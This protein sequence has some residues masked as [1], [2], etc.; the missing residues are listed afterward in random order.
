[1]ALSEE[2]KQTVIA[3]IN[4]ENYDA[5][6][7]ALSNQGYDNDH[8]EAIKDVFN[9]IATKKG[10]D[11]IIQHLSAVASA[12]E[13]NLNQKPHMLENALYSIFGET[14]ET[15]SPPGGQQTSQNTDTMADIDKL[16]IDDID[17]K[18]T[19][20]KAEQAKLIRENKPLDPEKSKLIKQLRAAKEKLA[21]QEAQA[22]SSQQQEKG[23]WFKFASRDEIGQVMDFSVCHGTVILETIKDRLNTNIKEN[24][25]VLSKQDAVKESQE[26]EFIEAYR[27]EMP[28]VSDGDEFIKEVGEKFKQH[29]RISGKLL[30]HRYGVEHGGLYQIAGGW[31]VIT[32]EEG[33]NKNLPAHHIY[34]L[35]INE[36][37]YFT[38]LFKRRYEGGNIYPDAYTALEFKG[39][40]CIT[41]IRSQKGID[42]IDEKQ[43][44]ILSSQSKAF[45]KKFADIQKE[46]P[47]EIFNIKPSIGE[48]DAIAK[49]LSGAKGSKSTKQ[50]SDKEKQPQQQTQQQEPEEPEK[51]KEEHEDQEEPPAHT[52]PTSGG[53]DEDKLTRLTN[54]LEQA[55]LNNQTSTVKRLE[56]E[57]AELKSGSKGTQPEGEKTQDEGP[58]AKEKAPEQNKSSPPVQEKQE[59]PVQQA[60]PE[61]VAE[62]DKEAE[63]HEMENVVDQMN[64]S[65]ETRAKILNCLSQDFDFGKIQPDEAKELLSK[66]FDD[67]VYDDLL[68]MRNQLLKAKLLTTIPFFDD[69]MSVYIEL[70]YIAGDYAARANKILKNSKDNSDSILEKAKEIH[71]KLDQYKNKKL[72]AKDL[73]EKMKLQQEL[74]K[75]EDENIQVTL[76]IDKARLYQNA[77]ISEIEKNDPN[78]E[79]VAYRVKAAK[80]EGSSGD[81]GR[82]KL[83]TEYKNKLEKVSQKLP[84]ISKTKFA[85]KD[86]LLSDEEIDKFNL[87]DITAEDLAELAIAVGKPIDLDDKEKAESVLDVTKVVKAL[88]KNLS[89]FFKDVDKYKLAMKEIKKELDSTQ[90]EIIKLE[91]EL[92]SLKIANK[93]KLTPIVEEK[94]LIEEK[95]A[96]LEGAQ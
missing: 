84:Q 91:K 45:H 95:L 49:A 29:K 59:A 24:K 41:I 56:A 83:L 18:I 67:L 79:H 65:K 55:K 68:K 15:L 87:Q 86:K 60:S 54:L 93:V 43:R 7:Q 22:D 32:R 31:L 3:A 72:S 94:R 46:I 16:S 48:E 82:D 33:D 42:V 30:E 36:N 52:A 37:A 20:I 11:T 9:N 74:Q 75:C 12:V 61:Q 4:S 6:A 78:P 77:D 92:D 64:F 21:G 1:M 39:N 19:E 57:I 17:N 34:P 88:D 35:G 26:K 96:H 44:A 47:E 53:A 58:P 81:V 23:G 51:H 38:V 63:F 13:Q 10:K 2:Q 50:E 80:D 85:L 71:K 73:N 5:A 89:H 66:H 70:S 8:N 76:D 28:D 27:N 90:R 69:Y 40:D 62:V 14:G 25:I